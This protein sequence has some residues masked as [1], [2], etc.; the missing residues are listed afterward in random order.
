VV[1]I[2]LVQFL[3]GPTQ[4]DFMESSLSTWAIAHGTLGCTYPTTHNDGIPFISPLYP[5]LSGGMAALLRIGHGIPFPTQAMLGPHCSKAFT[6]ITLWSRRTGA[7]TQTT[8]LGYL[9]WPVLMAGVVA[10]L[11]ATGR[12]RRLWEPL[13][14]LVL[15]CA[16]PVFMCVENQFHPQDLVA[17]GLALGGLACA[18]RNCWVWA[19]VLLGLAVTSQQFTLLVLAPLLVMAPSGRRAGFV[20]GALGAASVIFVPLVAFNTGR[21]FGPIVLGSGNTPSQGGTV[22]WEMHMHGALLVG[23]SRVLPILLAMGLAWWAIRRFGPAAL[24]PLLLVSIVATSLCLRLV[25]EQ[26]L[27]GYYLMA[28]AVSL[29]LLDVVNG[30]FTVY[31]IGWLALETLAFYPVPN[32]YDPLSRI[33]SVWILQLILVPLALV[34]AARPLF[35]GAARP[36]VGPGGQEARGS[37]PGDG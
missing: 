16:P 19:G 8:R 30:Q 26:N 34:L 4:S 9:A 7:A 36:L 23:V 37:D 29:V 24:S 1:F 5:L 18:R 6:A 25:F 2:A 33:N 31:L 17:M 22:L 27:F 32:V 21:S 10:L 14:L 3:G 13:T 11:R 15:A 28:I 20:A 35:S 12:G